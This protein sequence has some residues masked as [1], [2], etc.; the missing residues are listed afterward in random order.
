MKK[1]LVYGVLPIAVFLIVLYVLASFTHTGRVWSLYFLAAPKA[2]LAVKYDCIKETNQKVYDKFLLPLEFDE[3]SKNDLREYWHFSYYRACLF[4]AGY[5]F[6]GNEIPPT[7]LL[8]KDSHTEYT[9]Y[10]ADISLTL[11][12]QTKLAL[13]NEVN[14]DH[15]DYIIASILELDGNE[16]YINVDRSYKPANMATLKNEFAGFQSQ[17]DFKSPDLVFQSETKENVAAFSD[18]KLYGYVVLIPNRHI[19]K[20]YTDKDGSETLDQIMTTFKTIE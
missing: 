7:S 12:P 19:V 16:I 1:V 15:D 20:I 4:K 14:P 8:Q 2:P 10:F 18:G 3:V 6:W 9:N 17:K 5:D 13:D 11:P